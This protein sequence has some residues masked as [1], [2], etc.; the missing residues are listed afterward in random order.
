MCLWFFFVVF[1]PGWVKNDILW[2]NSFLQFYYFV[3]SPSTRWF[4]SPFSA[5]ANDRERF[6]IHRH[7]SSCAVVAGK[8][9]NENIVKCRLNFERG[10]VMQW[11]NYYY[12]YEQSARQTAQTHQQKSYVLW[13]ADGAVYSSLA[14]CRFFFT[15]QIIDNAI[16]RNVEN[17]IKKSPRYSRTTVI[18]A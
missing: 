18:H 3:R 9:I 6:G 11:T 14:G 12:Y 15:T 17:E 7:R 8:E 1:L 16:A 13:V 4:F 2:R 10:N 5:S